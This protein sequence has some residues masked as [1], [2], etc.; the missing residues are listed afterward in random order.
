ML[1]MRESLLSYQEYFEQLH[2]EKETL[3]KKIKTAFALKI[4]EA[5]GGMG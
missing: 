3:C 1:N 4:M 5:G 2:K